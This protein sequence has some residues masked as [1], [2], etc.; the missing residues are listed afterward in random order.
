MG[1]VTGTEGCVLGFFFKKLFL[2]IKLFAV[3][4]LIGCSF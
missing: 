3:F 4:F 1:F 2:V